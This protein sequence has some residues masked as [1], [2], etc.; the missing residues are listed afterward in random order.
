[1]VNGETQGEGGMGEVRLR[2]KVGLQEVGPVEHYINSMLAASGAKLL[3]WD[4]YMPS[5]CDQDDIAL[6]QQP[7]EAVTN[8]NSF[9]GL[10]SSDF[11]EGGGRYTVQ[12]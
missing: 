11:A 7:A 6:A 5:L 10:Y 4:F 12:S 3:E 1:M 9:L 8:K 2:F